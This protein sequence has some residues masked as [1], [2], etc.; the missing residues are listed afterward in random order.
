MRITLQNVNCK[1]FVKQDK[2]NSRMLMSTE[3]KEKLTLGFFV[4]SDQLCF[5]TFLRVTFSGILIAYCVVYR[6]FTL[7]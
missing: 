3:C 4:L 7:A 5:Q 2:E 6:V 1:L